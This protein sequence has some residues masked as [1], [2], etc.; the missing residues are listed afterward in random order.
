M[1]DAYTPMMT[2]ASF[3]CHHNHLR[4]IIEGE[5]ESYGLGRRVLHPFQ[6]RKRQKEAQNCIKYLCRHHDTALVQFSNR[7]IEMHLVFYVSEDNE[8]AVHHMANFVVDTL[9]LP[10]EF[11]GKKRSVYNSKS[12]I[13]ILQSE[14]RTVTD[15]QTPFTVVNIFPVVP[16]IDMD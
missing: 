8:N 14:K 7:E 13:R 3:L 4:F 16:E 15:G 11:E 12:S 2:E 6:V 5:Q 9:N 1:A 10:I